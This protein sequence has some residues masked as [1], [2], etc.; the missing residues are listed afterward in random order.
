M[1][2]GP[3]DTPIPS[4][5]FER[6]PPIDN[7]RKIWFG[8]AAFAALI[9]AIFL[10]QVAGVCG[11]TNCHS[12]KALGFEAGTGGTHGN[13]MLVNAYFSG[14]E[15]DDYGG[16][17]LVFKDPLGRG[18]VHD[19]DE[20]SLSGLTN[21]A[22]GA[23]PYCGPEKQCWIKVDGNHCWKS[24]QPDGSL[25]PLTLNEVRHVPAADVNLAQVWQRLYPNDPQPKRFWGRVVAC[26]N[27]KYN[28]ND[29]TVTPPCGKPAGET[30]RI[31]VFGK[32][33]LLTP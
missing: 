20:C 1:P 15:T 26:L 3:D 21:L 8:L 24:R 13:F 14:I 19:A 6:D 18:C 25:I 11:I 33:E 5:P 10:A 7:T 2:L 17:C 16:A 27:G 31:E 28:V 29:P 9:I 22:P 30:N 12:I 32:P 4:P 23:N